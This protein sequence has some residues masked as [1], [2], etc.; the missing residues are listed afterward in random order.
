[1][2]LAPNGQYETW[3]QFEKFLARQAPSGMFQAHRVDNLGGRISRF[4]SLFWPTGGKVRTGAAWLDGAL[5]FEKE[6]DHACL[7]KAKGICFGGRLLLV[8]GYGSGAK[9]R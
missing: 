3:N 1:M 6:K 7:A 5:G 8:A 9:T 2:H 4:K